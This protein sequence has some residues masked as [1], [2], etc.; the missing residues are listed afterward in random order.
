MRSIVIKSYIEPKSGK[1]K[2]GG[3]GIL[4]FFLKIAK[5]RTFYGEATRSISESTTVG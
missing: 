4:T 5:Q 2:S 3:F 1:K